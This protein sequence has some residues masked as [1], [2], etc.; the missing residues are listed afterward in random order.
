[1]AVERLLRTL[2]AAVNKCDK[3]NCYKLYLRAL[4][5]I[6]VIFLVSSRRGL[7]CCSQTNLRNPPMPRT[8]R[9]H[10]HSTSS[11][12]SKACQRYPLMKTVAK[13]CRICSISD[14]LACN[15]ILNTDFWILDSGQRLDLLGIFV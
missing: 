2:R 11:P 5:N 3:H 13:S 8:K 10:Y 9:W 15:L 14:F 1:M 12:N 4:K 7:T 6:L